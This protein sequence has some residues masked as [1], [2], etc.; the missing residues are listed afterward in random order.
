[1]KKNGNKISV[2]LDSE[3]EEKLKE[4]MA[5][6]GLGQSEAIRYVIGRTKV[7][8]IGNTKELGQEFCKIRMLLEERN[9]DIELERRAEELCQ[10]IKD[11]LRQIEE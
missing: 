8:Y 5:A 11:V 7:L 2:R 3:T 1:M 4:I 9:E 10:S 6:R